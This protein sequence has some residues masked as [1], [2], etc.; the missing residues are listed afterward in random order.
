[1][2]LRISC[3]SPLIVTTF[4]SCHRGFLL[5]LGLFGTCSSAASPPAWIMLSRVITVLVFITLQGI[6]PVLTCMAHLF[7][8]LLLCPFVVL[9][10][11]MELSLSLAFDR[12]ITINGIW[13]CTAYDQAVRSIS[14]C[15]TDSSFS[16]L[17][18]SFLWG[19]G[20]VVLFLHWNMYV[21]KVYPFFF[22][23]FILMHISSYFFCQI[24][25]QTSVSIRY[26]TNYILRSYLY[27][28]ISR[29][30][31]DTMLRQFTYDIL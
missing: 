22:W 2:P 14:C 31:D 15:K 23:N 16:C 3:K 17:S 24:Q 20:R 18:I 28:H 12:F 1:M 29:D 4:L 7:L 8:F 30:D 9:S 6:E 26:I 13:Q 27:V 21:S 5:F 10:S 19:Y 25:K 11:Y